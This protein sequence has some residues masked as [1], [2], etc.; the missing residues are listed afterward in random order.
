MA[1]RRVAVDHQAG[2]VRSARRDGLHHLRLY[3]R[4]GLC[5]VEAYLT[6]NSTHGSA[7]SFLLTADQVVID[8]IVRTQII[9]VK[10]MSTGSNGSSDERFQG[11]HARALEKAVRRIVRAH[12]LQ[13]RAL[14]KRCGLT[15]AQLVV[16]KGVAELGEVTSAALSVH[17]DISAATVVT[18]L[19]NLEERGLIQ[20]YRSGIDRRIVHTRLTDSGLALMEQAPEPM[21]ELFLDR[22]ARLAPQERQELADA[23]S[24]LGEL[25]SATT[26]DAEQHARA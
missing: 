20:R 2:P 11:S 21:G 1:K 8:L 5:P 24:R 17:A 3:E 13:S 7:R 15:A 25:M 4:R 6:T 18:I 16:M 23:V 19:D 10:G 22:F 9:M 26:R 14:A 12:D